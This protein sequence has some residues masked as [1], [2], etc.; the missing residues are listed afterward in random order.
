MCVSRGQVI[1]QHYYSSGLREK[2]VCDDIQ[3]CKML[4]KDFLN[5]C[6]TTARQYGEVVLPDDSTG[7]GPD[8]LA[9]KLSR[10]KEGTAWFL[11]SGYK[12][13][14]NR[15]CRGTK[16]ISGT[17][18]SRCNKCYKT[19]TGAVSRYKFNRSQKSATLQNLYCGQE[20]VS[21]CKIGRICH[22]SSVLQKP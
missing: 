4:L 22:G 13:Y 19:G 7:Q 20:R 10:C 21:G 17:N 5:Q 15:A 14:R 2:H 11:P 9:T 18:L 8:T 1:F 16:L 12:F 6:L 3:N